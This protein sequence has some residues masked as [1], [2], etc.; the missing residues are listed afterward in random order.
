MSTT[1][2]S[3]IPSSNTWFVS[4]LALV[5]TV[6]VFEMPCKSQMSQGGVML[7]PNNSPEQAPNLEQSVPSPW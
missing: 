6:N 4:M 7:V 1:A 2:G 5:I 3:N